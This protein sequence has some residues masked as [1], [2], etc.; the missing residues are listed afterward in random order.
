MVPAASV[1]DL[2]AYAPPVIGVWRNVLGRWR[3]T[4]EIGEFNDL[5]WT[6]TFN[7][8]G[9]WSLTMPFVEQAVLLQRDA[10]VTIEWRGK[11]TV[12]RI[13]LLNP[14]QDPE[15]EE[16]ALSI[17]S[18]GALSMVGWEEAWPN[19]TLGLNSQPVLSE[20]DPA[21]YKGP[22]ETV[23]KQ[24]VA[25][26]LRDRAGLDIVVPPS[27]G[28]GS[29]V[30]ARP[31]FDNCLELVTNLAKVGGVGVDL[32]MVTATP[33]A[34]VGDLTLRV[35]KPRDLTKAITLTAAAGSLEQ[36]EQNDT[37]PTATRAIVAGAGPG[38]VDRIRQIVTTPTSEAAA[39][40][41]GGHRT[42]FVDGPA[43]FDP[44]ELKQAGEQTLIE[45]AETRTLSLV[46]AETPHTLAFTHYDV[47]DK[48]T[49]EV[50]TGAAVS[51]TITS[52]GVTLGA[53]DGF[54]VSP[55]FGDPAASDVELNIA[56]R[57]GSTQ[58]AVRHLERK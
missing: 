57:I 46:A 17:T 41:W 28:L 50:L 30:T 16:P 1:T 35:W 22:A 15:T 25:G 55:T 6:P 49:A 39:A 2:E 20:T 58:R 52:I 26:N 21:P 43:T 42:V 18:V 7:D 56:N 11:R 40:A 14:K 31:A 38:G 36:W 53:A 44:E 47:G 4:G 5:S 24:I 10:L 45:G 29:T 34:T 51:D 48:A 23:I 13:G 27:T 33:N 9:T 54:T 8:V 32:E 19:P 3:R 12:W 37:E